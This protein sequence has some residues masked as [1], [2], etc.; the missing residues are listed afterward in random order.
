MKG[1]LAVLAVVLGVIVLGSK[2]AYHLGLCSGAEVRTYSDRVIDYPNIMP[3]AQKDKNLLQ[4][5]L[6]NCNPGL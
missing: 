1:E 4:N 3:V 5:M 2:V 6:D